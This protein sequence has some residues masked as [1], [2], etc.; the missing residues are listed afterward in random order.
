MIF[1]LGDAFVNFLGTV[2]FCAIIGYKEAVDGHNDVH[3]LPQSGKYFLSF[4]KNINVCK[5]ISAFC[6]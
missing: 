6:L 2:L 3:D 1:T 4:H 5:H